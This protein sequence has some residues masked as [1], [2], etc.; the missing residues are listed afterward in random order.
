MRISVKSAALCT[1]PSLSPRRGKLARTS[2][3]VDRLKKSWLLTHVGLLLASPLTFTQEE[4]KFTTKLF[5][6]REPKHQKERI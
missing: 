5:N 3:F 4:K 1:N 6:L 2:R